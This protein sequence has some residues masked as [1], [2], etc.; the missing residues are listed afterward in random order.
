MRC[1]RTDRSYNL[2]SDELSRTHIYMR[3]ERKR[4]LIIILW[5]A[6]LGASRAAASHLL[7][8]LMMLSSHGESA[9]SFSLSLCVARLDFQITPKLMIQF[10]IPVHVCAHSLPAHIFISH[11]GP[12]KVHDAALWRER[13]P[14][15]RLQNNF[16]VQVDESIEILT[17]PLTSGPRRLLLLYIERVV[18]ALSC[19]R[20]ATSGAPRPLSVIEMCAEQSGE[21]CSTLCLNL[22]SRGSIISARDRAQREL[23]VRCWAQTRRFA[24]FPPLCLT[25]SFCKTFIYINVKE[26]ALVA[27][28]ARCQLFVDCGNSS[29]FRFTL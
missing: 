6:R 8:F 18:Y 29:L 25:G 5:R 27:L 28:C 10:C 19:A 7:L 17:I 2:V 12:K 1:S 3:W 15:N 11:T 23:R 20:R 24:W 4:G 9:S 26:S 13:R 14:H 22:L 16:C 21:L